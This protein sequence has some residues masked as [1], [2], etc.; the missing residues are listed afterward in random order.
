MGKLNSEKKSHKKSLAKMVNMH[1]WFGKVH[2]LKGVDF[3][4]NNSEIVGLVGDNGAG[5]S[6][7]IK[8]LSGFYP[9]DEGEIYFEGKKETI[10]S[11]RQAR[12]LGI[13][14]V[15]QEQA[16]VSEMSIARNIFMGRE[17]VRPL[18][19]LNKKIMR[20]ESMEAL[21]SIELYLRSPDTLIAMLSG[22]ERQGVA[23]ARAL[24]FK[25]K[26][27]ILDEPTIALS[28]K[29]AQQVLE[30]IKQLRKEGIAAI[31]ITHNLYHAFPVAERFVILNRGE[32]VADVR[33]EDVSIDKL[34]DLIV[35]PPSKIDT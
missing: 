14:T 22:G 29:E 21:E 10:N 15:Y 25:A 27:V 4:V 1:K 30:F 32:R 34:S 31:F 26:L 19:F 24:H 23:I 6:T 8:V 12:K 7:L 5:K 9:A 17:P 28:I 18:G 13:E 2:A 3:E 35:K 16:L 20:N 11:P 33:K